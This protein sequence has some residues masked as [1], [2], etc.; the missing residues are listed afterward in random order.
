VLV[1]NGDGFDYAADVSRLGRG[2]LGLQ[3]QARLPAAAESP[4]QLTLV[5]AISRGER[6]DLT[7]QKATELGVSAIQPVITVRT[8]VRLKAEKQKR[9]M[10]HWRRVLIASCEQSGRARIPELAE[11]IELWAWAQQEPGLSRV[12]LL[13]GAS[14]S[15]ASLAAGKGFE[16]LVGP[17]GGFDDQELVMLKQEGIESASLGPRILRTETAGPAAI[18]ILQAIAGDLV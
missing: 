18:A 11:P 3:V 12:A 14:Q 15:L 13:P 4:L 9:R 1:F 16:L 2:E 5:Q 6:M 8:E 10:E 17:E 7:L